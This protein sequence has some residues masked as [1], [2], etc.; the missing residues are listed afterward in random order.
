[1]V[2]VLQQKVFPEVFSWRTCFCRCCATVQQYDKLSKA[3][4]QQVAANGVSYGVLID[5]GRL[6]CK[7]GLVVDWLIGFR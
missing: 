1:M 5:G 2:F 6:G 7:Q 3:V 4:P